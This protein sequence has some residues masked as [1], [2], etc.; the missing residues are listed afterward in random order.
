MARGKKKRGGDDG[1]MQKMSVGDGSGAKRRRMSP[2]VPF[3]VCL[4]CCFAVAAS[5]MLALLIANSAGGGVAIKRMTAGALRKVVHDLDASVARA[6]TVAHRT[7]S[8]G[9][10][11]K[12]DLDALADLVHAE[13][14]ADRAATRSNLD[15]VEAK[16]PAG[17]D[18]A[19]ASEDALR[20]AKERTERVLPAVV[21]KIEADVGA[22]TGGDV[23]A[24]QKVHDDAAELKRLD[25]EE[26]AFAQVAE[27]RALDAA[28]VDSTAK[29][30]AE[31]KADVLD[32]KKEV[33]ELD[34]AKAQALTKLDKDALRALVA[35]K[36]I[37]REHGA[38][39]KKL[40]HSKE[41]LS[42]LKGDGKAAAPLLGGNAAALPPK[43]TSD[44]S[45]E[46][47]AG[48][49]TSGGATLAVYTEEQQTRLGV[50]SAG[51]AAKHAVKKEEDK[52]S[53]SAD[54]STDEKEAKL[55]AEFIASADSGV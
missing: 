3:I 29:E 28:S 4:S 18:N 49:S 53:R 35:T 12:G 33:K 7:H 5:I 22:A 31:A 13:A 47:P 21:R 34:L 25:L 42:L 20:S 46:P 36:A 17:L 52:W 19:I 15:V 55:L 37:R 23:V 6:Q 24:V 41:L 11:L 9:D 16:K 30:K 45:V 1:E 54:V 32:V 8:G 48:A 14:K 50:G 44:S 10:V 2:Y 38:F 26:D 40:D 51:H 27:A 39:R 43:W